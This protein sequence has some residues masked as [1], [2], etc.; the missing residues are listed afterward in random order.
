MEP[1]RRRF[2]P[3]ALAVIGAAG[4]AALGIALYLLLRLGSD[5]PARPA[6]DHRLRDAIE[7]VRRMFAESRPLPAVKA[8]APVPPRAAAPTPPPARP[9]PQAAQKTPATAQIPPAPAE[10]IAQYGAGRA[11]HYR[12]S[13]EPALW[14]N[15]TLSY[16]I[17]ERGGTK[18]VETG[19]RHS[20][21]KMDFQLGTFAA[22]HPSHAS[23]RFPGFFMY[24]A[25]LDRP[26]KV[27]QRFSWEWP[28][29]LPGGQVRAGRVKRYES[30]VKAWENLP[31]YP[32]VKAPGDTFAVA[33]IDTTLSYI[34]DGALRA[35][36]HETLWYA[37]RYM[38]VVKVI[39][40]GRTPDEGAVLIVAEL[41]RH[42]VQ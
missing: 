5:H 22:G 20:G 28:W 11:W 31:A 42:E 4:L 34:E 7:E 17:V 10:L 37:W 41:V 8:P 13:V 33:R 14:R 18:V 39:R 24:A 1:P 26:L 9:V 16:R 15:A 36:A 6:E 32:S 38:Q 12:V 30:E 27:G 2:D 40:E 29:Q 23:M 3:A 21:G 25:Y 19:F 35:R